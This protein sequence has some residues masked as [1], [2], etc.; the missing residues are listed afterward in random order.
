MYIQVYE[1][2]KEKTRIHIQKS[3]VTD[4]GGLDLGVR[5]LPIFYL[6]I[7]IKRGFVVKIFYTCK[8]TNAIFKS[9]LWI[10]IRIHFGRQDP[11]PD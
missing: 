6:Y 11:D 3:K 8:K 7:C 1:S 9:V 2:I 5:E 10:R 4:L